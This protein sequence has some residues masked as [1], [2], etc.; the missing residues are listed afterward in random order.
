MKTNW[1]TQVMTTAFL[2]SILATGGA[3]GS[4]GAYFIPRLVAG[5]IG[6][7]I[8]TP[9]L[10]F[11][12]L[13]NRTCEGRFELLEGDFSHAKGIFGFNGS[14]IENG[15]LTV[16]LSP[17]EGWTG[18]LEKSDA[19]GF[20]GFGSWR[21]EGECLPGRDLAL[22]ADV[23]V[24]ILK[25]DGRY[26]I[27][28]QIGFTA[29]A[30]PSERW[31]FAA[32]QRRTAEA[33]DSTAFAVVPDEPG[34][35]NWTVDFYHDSGIGKLTRKGTAEGPLSLHPRGVRS[36]PRGRFYWIRDNFSRQATLPG[37][38]HRRLG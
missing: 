9:K 5:D 16:I 38:P 28:D 17:G 1:I 35:Y 22:S 23:E 20:T 36:R 26:R 11:K 13:S 8:F 10:S 12:N 2:V 18:K 15:V 37:G 7:I 21:Q 3:I 4:E 34:P 25:G 31:G 24:G 19:G 6:G 33:V 29:S 30:A 14:T 32:R 27:V